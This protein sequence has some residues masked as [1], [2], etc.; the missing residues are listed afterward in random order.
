V[1]PGYVFDG[2]YTYPCQC[3]CKDAAAQVCWTNG[4]KTISMF[5][6]GHPCGRGTACTFT[7]SRRSASVQRSIGSESFLF[8]GETGHAQLL[9]M[10]ASLKAGRSDAG[11]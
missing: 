9:K 7:R 8:L 2:A 6:C 11:A 3:G 1:P 5:E 4:L 10:A